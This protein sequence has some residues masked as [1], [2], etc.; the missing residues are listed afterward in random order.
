M[1]VNFVTDEPG[2]IPAIRAMLEPRFRV[3][4][5]VLQNDAPQ[6]GASGML[7]V[8]ADLRKM[9][10]VER[11]KRVL[12]VKRSNP[13]RMFVVP[14]HL[15]AMVAQAYALGATAVVSRPR[16]IISTL[17]QFANEEKAEDDTDTAVR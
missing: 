8:D 16:E 10:C 4:P 13:E 3:V 2:K 14:S 1:L 15:H 11:I 12:Q 6:I 7:M 17:T 5:Q 9:D